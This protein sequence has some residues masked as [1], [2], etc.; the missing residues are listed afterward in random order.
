VKEVQDPVV[1]ASQAGAQFVDA[2][3]QEVRFGPTQFMAH[4]AKVLQP[5]I[6]LVLHFRR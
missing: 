3:A 4:L 5:E 1:N 2:V 6:A